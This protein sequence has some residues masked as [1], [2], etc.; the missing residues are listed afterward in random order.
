MT[1]AF[2]DATGAA[3]IPM[4]VPATALV[5]ATAAVLTTKKHVVN[6]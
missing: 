1:G 4:H 2:E 6:H 5:V 3:A